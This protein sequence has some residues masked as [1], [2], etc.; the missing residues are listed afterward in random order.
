VARRVRRR[1]ECQGQRCDGEQR[2]HD[3]CGH[4]VSPKSGSACTIRSLGTIPGTSFRRARGPLDLMRVYDVGRYMRM[5]SRRH[6]V[7]G[8]VMAAISIGWIPARG[9]T[10]SAIRTSPDARAAYLAHAVI[11]RDPGTRSPADLLEGPA[12]AFPYTFE[13]ATSPE[14][15]ACTFVQRGR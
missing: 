12:G 10:V 5:T 15:I 9:T 3:R 2:S 13:Q 7:A 4:A 11:W 6:G 14:G 8:A 1:L